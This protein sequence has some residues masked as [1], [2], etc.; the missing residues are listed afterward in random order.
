MASG[1][2]NVYLKFR[3]RKKKM[4]DKEVISSKDSDHR[5]L[6]KGTRLYKIQF[7]SDGETV[8]E[9]TVNKLKERVNKLSL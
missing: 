3:K 8:D 6:F 1:Y 9:L 7:A 5:S 2:G 4:E